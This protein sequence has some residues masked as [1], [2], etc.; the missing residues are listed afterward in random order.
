MDEDAFL[1]EIEEK[2]SDY[3]KRKHNGEQ[4]NNIKE[5]YSF[6][7]DNLTEYYRKKVPTSDSE[8]CDKWGKFYNNIGKLL[9]NF[10]CWDL[11]RQQRLF[12]RIAYDLH[13][14]RGKIWEALSSIKNPY[15]ILLLSFGLFRKLK[16]SADI[17]SYLSE[18]IS[19]LTNPQKWHTFQQNNP[20]VLIPAPWDHQ[21]EAVDTWWRHHGMGLI[22]M[23]TGTG[24]T[25]V[26]FLAIEKL[27]NFLD[28]TPIIRVI[29][30]QLVLLKQWENS[31]LKTFGYDSKPE[32]FN[33][34][35]VQSIIN[36]PIE[37]IHSDLIIYDEIHR[38]LGPQ[39]QR[40]L[41]LPAKHK[42]GMSATVKASTLPLIEK[43]IGNKIFDLPFEKAIEQK[44]ILPFSVKVYITNLSIEEQCQFEQKTQEIAALIS[45]ANAVGISNLPAL[46]F[47]SIISPSFRVYCT[48][49][50]QLLNMRREIIHLSENKLKLTKNLLKKIGNS[51]KVIAFFERIETMDVIQKELIDTQI[52]TFILHS[53]VNDNHR[54]EIFK[55]FLNC[56]KGIL[57]GAKMISSGIDIPDA[58]IGINVQ[59]EKNNIQLRQRIGRL[60]RKSWIN[61]GKKPEFYQIIAVPRGDYLDNEEIRSIYI[62][63]S[64]SNKVEIEF[65]DNTDYQRK[66]DEIIRELR[67]R[68]NKV[69]KILT[70]SDPNMKLEGINRV[71]NVNDQWGV[72]ALIIAMHCDK[73]K[74]VQNAA[75]DK[76]N[77]LIS[78][79]P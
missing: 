54:N 74:S 59:F 58:E 52:P 7:Q 44:I 18:I 20:P 25:M 39:F 38:L 76:Y 36:Q 71:M 8:L 23:A 22:E 26:A 41:M 31:F 68:I 45:N 50:Q 16:N 60:S 3:W 51:K 1:N 4:G 40:S 13:I 46:C 32:W 21:N 27:L 6:I 33:T 10:Y 62:F 75:K 14:D 42:M 53:G 30:D 28:D 78:N 35:T 29:C 2:S 67:N 37:L 11:E 66:S 12:M 24:K 47:N 43:F 70:D 64:K 48:R 63:C 65:C 61:P 55:E 72:K 19:Y 15:S 5:L 49:Y 69:E 17:D 56:D 79:S 34:H 73:D 77:K 57:L 9:K